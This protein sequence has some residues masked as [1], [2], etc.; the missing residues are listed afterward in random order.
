MVGEKNVKG[1]SERDA[2]FR[3]LKTGL[4]FSS[5]ML[6][7]GKYYLTN[8]RQITYEGINSRGHSKKKKR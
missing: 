2:S 7:R 8:L 3:V 6:Y 5:K 1:N 4:I